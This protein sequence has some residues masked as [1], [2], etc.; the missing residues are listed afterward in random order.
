MRHRA[1][2]TETV[3]EKKKKQAVSK[4]SLLRPLSHQARGALSQKN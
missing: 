4:A 2:Y 3:S 1:G